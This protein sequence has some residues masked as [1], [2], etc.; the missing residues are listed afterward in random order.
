[1]G[2]KGKEMGERQKISIEFDIRNKNL[3]IEVD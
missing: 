2:Q 1:M 3:K